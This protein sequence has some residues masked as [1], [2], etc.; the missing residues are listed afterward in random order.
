MREAYRHQ[1]N[2]LLEELNGKQ[3]SLAVFLIYTARE[4]PEPG[5]IKSAMT[6]VIERLIKKV[7]EKTSAAS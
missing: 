4:L 2:I 5:V 3:R 6:G 1:K 7:N